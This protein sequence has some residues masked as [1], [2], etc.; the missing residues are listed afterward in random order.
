M[1]AVIKIFYTF[2]LCVIMFFAFWALGYD[3]IIIHP[4]LSRAGI[5]IY[6]KNA[7]IKLTNEQVGWMVEGS[8]A[9]DTDPRYLN[10]FYDPTTG[11]GLADGMFSGKSAKEWA[12]NQD[13]LTGDYSELAILENYKQGDYKRAYQGIGHILHLIQDMSV[14]AHTRNDAHP[15]GDPYEKW[16]E[17]NG[18]TDSSRASFIKIN[19]L[20]QAFNELASYSHNNFFSKDTI[21]NIDKYKKATEVVSGKNIGYLIGDVDGIDFKLAYSENPNSISPIYLIDNS[22]VHLDYWNILHPKA[23]GYSAGV[24]DYFI[25]KFKQIDQQ[26]KEKLSLWSKTKN[27]F[28]ELGSDTKYVLGDSVISARINIP[29]IWNDAKSAVVTTAEAAKTAAQET[30]AAIKNAFSDKKVGPMAGAANI[31]QAVGMSYPEQTNDSH[32]EISEGYLSSVIPVETGI[33]TQPE[34]T[35]PNDVQ[36]GEASLPVEFEAR[37]PSVPTRADDAPIHAPYQWAEVVHAPYGGELAV[38][39]KA[40]QSQSSSQNIQSVNDGKPA[41]VGAG[42]SDVVVVENNPDADSSPMVQNDTANEEAAPEAP[43]EEIQELSDVIPVRQQADDTPAGIQTQEEPQPGSQSEDPSP[44]AQND[45]QPEQVADETSPETETPQPESQPESE[46]EPQPT[47][48]VIASETTQSQ[49]PQINFY[50]TNYNVRNRNF[51]L[52]W[53]N[54]NNVVQ[55]WELQYKM[56]PNFGWEILKQVQDDIEV[57]AYNYDFTAQYDD[58][59]YYFRLRGQDASGNYT[60]WKTLQADI[61]TSPIVINEIAWRGTE[62]SPYDEWIELANKTDQEIDI[63]D[64]ILKTTDGNI[65]VKLTGKIAANGFYLLERATESEVGTIDEDSAIANIAAD[66][67]Y[68][69]ALTNRQYQNEPGQNLELLDKDNI[70][71]DNIWTLYAGDNNTS[72]TSERINIWSNSLF[73]NNWQSYAGAGSDG[74]DANGNPVYGTPRAKNSQAGE[75][76]ALNSG[77]SEAAPQITQ[78]IIFLKNRGPYMANGPIEIRGA[79]AYVEPGTKFEFSSFGFIGFHDGGELIAKGAGNEKIYIKSSNSG[80]IALYFSNGA[81]GELDNVEIEGGMVRTNTAIIK[82]SNSLFKNGSYGFLDLLNG[83]DFDISN[84]EFNGNNYGDAIVIKQSQGKIY[85]NNIKNNR[86]DGIY[87]ESLSGVLD[88]SGNSFSGNSSPIATSGFIDFDLS[89]NVFDNGV[90]ELLV[91]NPVINDGEVVIISNKISYILYDRAK[92]NDW[93]K[94][95]DPEVKASGILKIEPGAIV[96]FNDNSLLK[97]NGRLEASGTPENPIVFKHLWDY[98]SYGDMAGNVVEMVDSSKYIQFGEESEYVF[99]NVVTR[100]SGDSGYRSYWLVKE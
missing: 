58:I 56:G 5:E 41:F 67:I 29:I 13:S 100:E 34:I 11:K 35:R 97:V 47:D 27:L 28:S 66:Q 53:N 14:P 46:P 78:D 73:K 32:P 33:Q 88:I 19:N 96:K 12:Q 25:N 50:L 23:V 36:S 77:V 69:G 84:N 63:N 62:A 3:N 10:H 87:I 21:I 44:E 99:E 86:G 31:G 81:K 4:K 30:V 51:I 20:N 71:I 74:K 48:D 93:Y 16:A 60:D 75:Y 1:K 22:K 39:N 76:F 92:D 91:Y 55:S 17:Q 94:I 45:T 49:S 70:K 90:Y 95:G 61:S 59:T 43:Q 98:A 9:E 52:N 82:I 72:R 42:I 40:E 54:D 89:N 65:N 8:I 2:S 7:D 6:N 68:K 83:S 24:I 26:E 18:D 57:G 80:G 79:K 64:W 15:E 85:S 37:N 38:E